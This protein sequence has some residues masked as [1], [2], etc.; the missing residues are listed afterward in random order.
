LT[1][2][3]FVSWCIVP[4]VVSE[5]SE[6]I[7][8][9]ENHTEKMLSYGAAF[10]LEYFNGNTWVDIPLDV[11]W[12][13]PIFSVYPGETTEGSASFLYSWVQEF[14]N[15]KE[16]KY[17]I[18]REYSLL[19]GARFTLHAEFYVEVCDELSAECG[20]FN[21]TETEFVSWCIVPN[22]VSEN[23]ENIIRLENRTEK[24]LRFWIGYSLE[25]FNGNYWEDVLGDEVGFPGLDESLASGEITEGGASFLYRWVQEF[26]NSKKGKYRLV[27]E[28]YSLLSDY[29]FG[30]NSETDVRFSLYA[31]FI[32]E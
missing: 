16:G 3:E 25:Y 30:F 31:E 12:I 6:N 21:L 5:N 19:D 2:T 13:L 23:S 26:N 28:Q 1:E 29:N 20:I 18:V 17:R 15:S 11:E 32:V 8:R 24:T 14:N 27:R 4:N 10:S 9:L 22:V 7:F